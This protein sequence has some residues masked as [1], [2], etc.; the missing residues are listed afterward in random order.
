M[1]YLQLLGYVKSFL[2]HLPANSSYFLLGTLKKK[3]SDRASPDTK[4]FGGGDKYRAAL[5]VRVRRIIFEP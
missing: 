4:S 3:N 5:A 1:S 2:A